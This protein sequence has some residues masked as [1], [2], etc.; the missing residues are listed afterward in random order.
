MVLGSEYTTEANKL[1]SA[2]AW[3]WLLEITTGGLPATLRYTNNN[4]NVTWNGNG[5]TKLPFNLDD[6]SVTT[7]G[8]FPEFS[9]HIWEVDIEGLL[10]FHIGLT[11]GLVGKQVRLMVVH[12]EHLDV[13]TAA[14]DEYT[15]ILGCELIN[16]AVTFQIGQPTLLSRRFPRSRYVP[17]F[18]RHKFA[19][20]LCKYAVSGDT[21]TSSQVTFIDSTPHGNY[22]T[23]Q[24][25]DGRLLELFSNAPG[26]DRADGN[27]IT[28]GNF[29]NRTVGEPTGWRAG[30]YADDWETWA[31]GAGASREMSA[32]KSKF[33]G[34]SVLV[35]CNEANGGI[36][37]D[38]VMEEGGTYTISCWVHVNYTTGASANG[39]R[40]EVITRAPVKRTFATY[41]GWQQ[42]TITLTSLGILDT[43][44]RVALGGWGRAFFDGISVVEGG[45]AMD[46]TERVLDNP[47]GFTVSGSAS[48]DGH[49]LVLNEDHLED[50]YVRVIRFAE[51]AMDRTFNNESPGAEVTLQLG[52][53]DCDHT[54]PACRIR[55]NSSNFGGSPGIRG[56]VYG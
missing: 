34:Q 20:A 8:A 9:L 56:G 13:T 53:S 51:Y 28:N 55:D 47:S 40:M 35:Q 3:I 43:T 50:T 32:E 36:Y 5:Y 1:S 30:Y 25:A 21:L 18:C 2:G 10:Y 48:N 16:Q 15:E 17:S 23:I 29:K 45:V 26:F 39:V 6:F 31:P 22:N 49:F 46:Y 38:V 42:L 24:V 41:G 11:N 27:L 12:S 52:Y 19:G 54:L 33:D 14:I 7:S 44:L 4:D 37:Q